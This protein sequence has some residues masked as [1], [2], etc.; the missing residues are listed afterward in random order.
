MTQWLVTFSFWIAQNR[1]DL[2]LPIVEES[3]LKKHTVR[4]LQGKNTNY[5]K[6]KLELY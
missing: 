1:A 6:G 5:S 2:A 4:S 3:K